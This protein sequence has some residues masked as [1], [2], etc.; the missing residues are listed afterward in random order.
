MSKIRSSWLKWLLVAAL[1]VALA[2]GVARA[3]NKRKTTQAE[4][5][6]AAVA[7]QQAAVFQLAPSDVVTVRT[8]RLS[9][10]VGVSGSINAMQSALIKAKTPGEVSGLSKREGENVVAGEV[11]ARIDS[12]EAQARVRQAEQQAAAALAQKGIAQ[13][14][15]DNNQ[16]LVQKGFISS[17]ALETSSANLAAAQANHQ[18]ALAALD[19]ARKSLGDTT[20]R[21][22]LAGQISARMVQ[23]GERVSIDARIFEVLDLSAFELEAALAPVDAASIKAGQTAQLKIEG[24]TTP[25]NAEVTRINPNVQAGSRSVMVYLRVPSADGMRQGLFAQGQVVT[26]ELEGLAVPLSSVR[27]DKPKP[28]VQLVREGKIAYV[29]VSLSRQALLDGEPML[30]ID[31]SP[32]GLKAGDAVLRA[33]AGA[34]REGTAV[35]LASAQASN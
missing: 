1:A 4:A 22:P 5:Q 17:T 11:L 3:L 24:L 12:T 30:L 16:S 6:A 33:Q 23:N 31:E 13:R 27:N 14:A 28:Y 20:L 10:A 7:L 26:G 15:Q 2:L 32:Q 18:A 9:Q 25:V 19:I 34:I 29:N 21:S 35:Q 8:Q